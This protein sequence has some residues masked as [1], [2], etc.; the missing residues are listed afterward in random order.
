M[1]GVL[2]INQL[3]KQ[4][5]VSRGCLAVVLK[6]TDQK[7]NDV[8]RVRRAQQFR[9]GTTSEERNQTGKIHEGEPGSK[10]EAFFVKLEL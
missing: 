6:A 2:E 3:L 7:E 4:L 10:G 8:G 1:N 9:S 5:G